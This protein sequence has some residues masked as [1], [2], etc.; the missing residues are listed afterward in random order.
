[1]MDDLVAELETEME[2]FA[3]ESREELSTAPKQE[4]N[5]EVK[6]SIPDSESHSHAQP[7]TDD[8]S[9]ADCSVDTRDEA[10]RELVKTELWRWFVTPVQEGSK[11]YQ[12]RYYTTSTNP[13]K[14]NRKFHLAPSMRKNDETEYLEL[15]RS[16]RGIP[17]SPWIVHRP[18]L[19]SDQ[20]LH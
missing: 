3:S 10:I 9:R 13:I 17:T 11:S 14:H 20:Y 8:I 1:M 19:G 2:F 5:E 12:L 7:S 6:H 4:E 16:S 15:V 18:L